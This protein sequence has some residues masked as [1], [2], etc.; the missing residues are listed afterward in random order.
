[1]KWYA[2]WLLWEKKNISTWTFLQRINQFSLHLNSILLTTVPLILFYQNTLFFTIRNWKSTSKK[3]C[4]RGNAKRHQAILGPSNIIPLKTRSNPCCENQHNGSGM[5][6]KAITGHNFWLHLQ[7]SGYAWRKQTESSANGLI[8]RGERDATRLLHF[9]KTHVIGIKLKSIQI[10]RLGV[11][12]LHVLHLFKCI[13]LF[14]VWLFFH[15]FLLLLYL[16]HY[17]QTKTFKHFLNLC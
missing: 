10:R 13:L 17:H 12:S 16:C 15:S 1:M 5:N 14:I 9:L 3:I 4:V 7:M 8:R 11:L 6:M 2:T